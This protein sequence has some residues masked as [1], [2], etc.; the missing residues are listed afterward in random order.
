MR[1]IKLIAATASI[2]I[3]LVVLAGCGSSAIPKPTP[4]AEEGIQAVEVTGY[5]EITVEDS[6]IKVTGETNLKT[7][8]LM[9]IS[10]VAQNGM[11]IESTTI[12]KAGDDAFEAV[13]QMSGDKYGE[14]VKA[15]TAFVTAGPK[16]PKKQSGEVLKV[17]G[18]KFEQITNTAIWNKDGNIVTFSSE[19]YEF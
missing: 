4:Q 17:Y 1:K 18:S 19:P 9:E 7:G 15:I 5:C 13:F 2:V 11:E 3:L 16:T 10:I 6:A 12:T 14:N 8:T